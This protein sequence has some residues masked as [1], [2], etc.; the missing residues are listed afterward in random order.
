MKF[1]QLC[2]RNQRSCKAHLNFIL[3]KIHAQ[4]VFDFSKKWDAISLVDVSHY[5]ELL[6]CEDPMELQF[7][8]KECIKE[9]WKVRELKRQINSSLFQWLALSTNK[10]GVL[11]PANEGYEVLTPANIIHDPYVLE[12]VEIPQHKRYKETELEKASKTNIEQFL[13][14]SDRC[15]YWR[16]DWCQTF[17]SWFSVL[18][19]NSKVLCLDWFE[20]CR[21]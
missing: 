8:M 17:Q 18:S 15:L 11:A 5:F 7:Y 20:T 1:R 10:E 6:K 16:T 13:L 14:E 9:S 21:N 2:F 3:S 4:T 19:R 12:F